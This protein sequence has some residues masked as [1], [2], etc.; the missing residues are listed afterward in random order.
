MRLL[1]L[2][3][4]LLALPLAAVANGIG[5]TTT[6]AAKP[7]AV[8]RMTDELR[9]E[10]EKVTI[11][12][13]QSVQWRN[14]SGMLHTVTADPAKARNRRNVQLPAGAATFDSGELNTGATF[15]HT[16]NVSG[17]Y[18]YFCI[19][20]ELAGMVGEVEVLPATP[21]A[22]VR[23]AQAGVGQL[24]AA[25]QPAST[26]TDQDEDEEKGE[27]VERFIHWIGEFHPAMIVFPVGVLLAGAL[28]ELLLIVKRNPFYDAAGR[29]CV[30]F[31]M[32]GAW[33]AAPLGWC[34]AGLHAVDK[35]WVMTTHRWLG[36]AMF[37]WT[38]VLL[39]LYMRRRTGQPGANA[40][41]RWAL[42]VAA[43]L[44]GVTAY[45]GGAVTLGIN[46]Y[47]W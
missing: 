33:V 41:F 15:E 18:R 27:G 4:T 14:T 44:L 35:D 8:V 10:P 43:L 47:A 2:C 31:G 19:P 32:I 37:L 42:L 40:M 46:H 12:Q 6:Q 25:A 13:G 11:R 7:A 3:I 24:A 30:M 45:F 34:L 20:H 1:P 36:T 21:I 38:L 28:A 26:Q 16:F 29:Y 5:P 22:Q 9:Y 17:V 23:P 39:A